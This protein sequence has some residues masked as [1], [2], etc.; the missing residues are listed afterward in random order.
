M[1]FQY[2][3]KLFYFSFLMLFACN[4]PAR[5]DDKPTNLKVA[6]QFIDA[7][8]SFNK[9][10]L[11][12]ALAL[13]EQSQPEILYYQKWAECAHY[14]VLSRSTAFEKNDSLVVFP[15][16]V[17]DDLMAALNI[18]FN[19]TDTF[20]I[21]IQQ[22]KIRSVTTSSND[23]T[24]YWEA[25]SWVKSNHPELVEKACAGAWAGGHTPCDCVLGMIQGFREFVN[26]KG[27]K[28]ISTP[29]VP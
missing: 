22:G 2:I 18:N 11:Q 15:V 13:A 4:P 24:T 8:Y 29:L 14:K 5:P 7:F 10:S 19:V 25:K 20:R 23:P 21:V 27:F 1:C 26:H 6:N 9:D 12:A 16:T 17:K 3:S 28:A